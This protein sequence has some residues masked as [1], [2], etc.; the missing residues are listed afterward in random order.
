MSRF[1]DTYEMVKEMGKIIGGTYQRPIVLVIPVLCNIA[2]N[3]AAIADAL[4][5]EDEE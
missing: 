4:E 2:L 3:L 1:S 5:K